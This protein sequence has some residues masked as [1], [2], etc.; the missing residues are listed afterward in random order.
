MLV[1]GCVPSTKGEKAT[2]KE[3]YEAMLVQARQCTLADDIIQV[4]APA[5]DRSTVLFFL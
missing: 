1:L 5:A 2:G 4:E 3:L